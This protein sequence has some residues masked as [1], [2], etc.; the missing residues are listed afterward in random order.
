MKHSHPVVSD[1]A[2]VRTPCNYKS[3]H[4]LALR[5]VGQIYPARKFED[6][7]TVLTD[8]GKLYRSKLVYAAPVPQSSQQ[9]GRR[10]ERARAEQFFWIEA[11]YQERQRLATFFQLLARQLVQHGGAEQ[12]AAQQ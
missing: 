4:E 9:R 5:I 2:H 3:A 11:D 10:Q 7:F 12:A 6:G 1:I 8:G